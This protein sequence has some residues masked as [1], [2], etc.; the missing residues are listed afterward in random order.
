MIF[1]WNSL[2]FSLAA[3]DE[4]G[5]GR[6]QSWSPKPNLKRSKSRSL[7][8][9][10][11]KNRITLILFGNGLS[12]FSWFVLIG[13]IGGEIKTVVE[14]WCFISDNSSQ[15]L[16]NFLK[17]DSP[18]SILSF[19]FRFIP[20]HFPQNNDNLSM[21]SFEIVD[22][23]SQPHMWVSPPN[24]KPSGYLSGPLPNCLSFHNFTKTAKSSSKLIVVFD[25]CHSMMLL[26]VK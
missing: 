15:P 2:F 1:L 17:F 26:R 13:A 3:Q 6:A 5:F 19:Y 9:V 22:E 10:E 7:G 18:T 16:V 23:K 24:R 25:C 21:I 12:P 20:V 8:F 11:R 14:F 4:H